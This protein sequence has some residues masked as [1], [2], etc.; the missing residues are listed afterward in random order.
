MGDTLLGEKGS[1]PIE[2]VEE[3]KRKWKEATELAA[4][5]QENFEE[6]GI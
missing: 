5:I 1:E 3:I 2:S 4:K 6:L